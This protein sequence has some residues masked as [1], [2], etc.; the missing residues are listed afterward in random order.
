MRSHRLP[1]MQGGRYT[2][3]L[4]ISSFSEACVHFLLMVPEP[5]ILRSLFC[6]FPLNFSPF[7]VSS[8]P[9]HLCVCVYMCVFVCVFQGP[10][11]WFSGVSE[12]E[13]FKLAF[14]TA[15]T[16]VHQS[17][18]STG[19]PRQAQVAI[20]SSWGSSLHSNRTSISCIGRH[21]FF[22]FFTTEPPGKPSLL[23]CFQTPKV[24]GPTG[25][26]E[27][28]ILASVS[29]KLKFQWLEKSLYFFVMLS[30]H[31]TGASILGV[32][33]RISFLTLVWLCPLLSPLCSEKVYSMWGDKCP[34]RF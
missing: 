14:V 29:D 31:S 24:L 4:L 17:P 34:G 13:R 32:I 15:W 21:Y 2:V 22:G 8:H 28:L 33:Q 25:T 16:V 10:F 1:T 27:K 30:T 6:F 7:R 20:S 5:L 23:W 26:C 9:C 3:N 19:F 11:L 12:M 18:L